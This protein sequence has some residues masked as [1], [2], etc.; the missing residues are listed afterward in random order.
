MAAEHCPSDC[1]N[2]KAASD[3]SH[4]RRVAP[5]LLKQPFAN[6]G[7]GQFVEPWD[8]HGRLHEDTAEMCSTDIANTFGTL[9]R[10]RQRDSPTTTGN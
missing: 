9:H 5:S 7:T 6:T 8:V 1:R 3:P 4:F 2:Q 10:E